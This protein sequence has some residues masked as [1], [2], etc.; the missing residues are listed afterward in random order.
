[1]V[2]INHGNGYVTRY[3][4]ALAKLVEVGERISK[5]E[6]IAIIGNS[7]RSTGTHL[8]FEVIKNGRTINPRSY[9]RAKG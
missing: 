2:E 4:H 8:H 7:G 1:M 9:L 5:G 3:A 6:L